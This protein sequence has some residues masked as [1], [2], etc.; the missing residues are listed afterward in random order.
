M[1]LQ[2]FHIKQVHNNMGYSLTLKI[3][4]YDIDVLRVILKRNQ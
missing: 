1:T 2:F 3:L 4:F